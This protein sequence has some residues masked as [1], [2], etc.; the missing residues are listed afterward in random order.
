MITLNMLVRENQT[1][2]GEDDGIGAVNQETLPTTVSTSK[3][4]NI[5]P[6]KYG[7]VGTRIVFENGSALVVTDLYQAVLD[8]WKAEIQS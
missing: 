8:A 4:R 6:R 1:D 3:I 2:E 7:K 5:H